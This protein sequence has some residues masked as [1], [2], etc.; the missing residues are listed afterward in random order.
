MDIGIYIFH[1]DL[2]II[3]NQSLNYL[4]TYTK[5]I[6]P[7]FLLDQQQITLHKSNK[8]YFSNNAVQF[9]C[10]SLIELNKQ[11]HNK[12]LILKNHH[13]LTKLFKFL[14]K[15][16]KQIYLGYHIDFSEY[17]EKRDNKIDQLAQSYSIQIIKYKDDFSL[18]PIK[19]LCKNDGTGFK[20]FGAFYKFITQYQVKKSITK[21][22][23]IIKIPWKNPNLSKLY[24]GNNLLA[25]HGGRYNALHKLNN[26]KDFSNYNELR[27]RL[28]YETTNL[29]AYLNLG[30]VSIREV[31]WIFIKKLRLQNDLIKQLYWRD[32]YL[33]ALIYLPNAKK[34]HHLDSRYD[35]LHWKNNYYLWKKLINASTGFLLIDAAINQLK[36]TGYLHNRARILLGHFWTK[37]LLINPFHPKYGS[38]VGFSKYLVD[39]IGTSQNKFNNHWLT[40]FD[41]AGRRYAPKN[42][43]LAG[44]PMD[45]NNIYKFDPHCVYIKKWL[46]HLKKI[47]NK[48]LKNWT[49]SKLHPGPIFELKQKYKEWI[50]ICN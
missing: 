1:R 29:S 20:Q 2:R 18:V 49:G 19:Y 48:I 31:Y 45:I 22:F 47:D 35:K 16:Y 39:A 34:Y 3:D 38:Q 13:E 6:I 46:P 17:S 50:K 14:S 43:P 33:Q 25:Q 32:F 7:I 44:R 23:H 42:I 9:I 28:D 21:S 24:H 40:E 12:L 26:I 30:L 41:L 27:D 10:E 5:N 4:T 11:L 36:Q 15:K 8:Y 37:Y